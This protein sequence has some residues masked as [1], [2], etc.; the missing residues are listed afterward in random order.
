MRDIN[1]SN[2]SHVV[3]ENTSLV[4]S[5][6][7]QN[8]TT[9]SWQLMGGTDETSQK[10]D[11]KIRN[12]FRYQ[13]APSTSLC[14][15]ILDLNDQ[16]LECGKDLL[17]MCDN[18]SNFLQTADYQVE[19]FALI[20]NMI[21]HLLH[22][23]KVKLL[24][25]SSTNIISLCD[26]YLSL[27]D[28]LEQLL[29][30]NCSNIPSLYELRNT[31]SARRI[32]N[33]LLEEE[34]HELAMNMSTKCGLDTQTVWASWG[35]LELRRGNYSDARSKFDKCLKGVND[36]NVSI[37]QPQLKILND[38]LNYFE[39][40]PPIRM[41]GPQTLLAPLRS[42][43]SLIAEPK[44]YSAGNSTMDD[45]Q[46]KEAIFYLETYGNYS[47]MLGFYQS[48]GY[49][50]NSLQY[51]MDKKCSSDVFVESLLVPCL[52]NGEFYRLLEN[53]LGLERSQS[54]LYTYYASIGKYL[55]KNAYLHTLYDFQLLMKDYVRACMSCL[56]F[57]TR[58]AQNYADLFKNMHFLVKAKSHLEQYFEMCSVKQQSGLLNSQQ[59]WKQKPEQQN[60]CK[61][62]P[63]QEVN[64]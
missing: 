22:N 55:E 21:K 25:N 59:Q 28:V 19:D 51:L 45:L 31:E 44:F 13:Q 16:P 6:N 60:L 53:M 30:A 62:M 46:L 38:I 56:C 58:N 37:N 33:R 10:R 12:S 24:Q 49:L 61:Q 34:R 9:L 3:Y 7:A 54:K 2:K 64:K 47:L 29:L 48:H 41:L 18:L 8:E 63:I 40:A 42:V 5:V 52:K 57:F 14:L 32:R 50:E 23:A 36:K 39:N 11:E 35:M 20:I 1:M 15:S 17:T 26:T 27:I 43:D 4:E